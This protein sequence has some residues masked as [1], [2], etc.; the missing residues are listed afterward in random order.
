VIVACFFCRE[1]HLPAVQREV[2]PY[3]DLGLLFTVCVVHREELTRWRQAAEACTAR[4]QAAAE[5][6]RQAQGEAGT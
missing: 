5:R 1:Q 6:E 3:D 4:L 2:P